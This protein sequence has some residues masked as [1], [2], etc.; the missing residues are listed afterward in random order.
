MDC[1]DKQGNFDWF[2]LTVS[3]NYP[4]VSCSS[5][6]FLLDLC[7]LN[8][9]QLKIKSH[10]LGL[11]TPLCFFRFFIFWCGNYVYFNR[12]FVYISCLYQACLLS[13][14]KLFLAVLLSKETRQFSSK[15]MEFFY[16]HKSAL[17][18][19]RLAVIKTIVFSK[20]WKWPARYN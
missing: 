12:Q 3:F 13:T 2:L 7:S 16:F 20:V 11:W 15:V 5:S 17:Q 1:I 10:C 4:I 6:F 18:H 9:M 8:Q 14:E 19:L